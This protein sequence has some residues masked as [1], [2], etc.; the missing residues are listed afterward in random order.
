ML[1]ASTANQS[2]R[3]TRCCRGAQGETLTAGGDEL[4]ERLASGWDGSDPALQIKYCILSSTR[5]RRP[6]PLFTNLRSHPRFTALPQE[7]NLA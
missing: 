2:R 3:K 4:R 5:K 6:A 7:M 1:L